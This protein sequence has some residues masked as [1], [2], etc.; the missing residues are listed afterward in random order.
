[1]VSLLPQ[2]LKYRKIGI[3]LQENLDDDTHQRVVN[4]ILPGIGRTKRQVR[5][6][7]PGWTGMTLPRNQGA[8]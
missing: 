5:C 3:P 8:S 4:A 1:M 2:A 7:H 6:L